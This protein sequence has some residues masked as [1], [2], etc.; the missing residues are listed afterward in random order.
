MPRTNNPSD[1][2]NTTNSSALSGVYNESDLP[3]YEFKNIVAFSTANEMSIGQLNMMFY[4]LSHGH[5]GMHLSTLTRP[6]FFLIASYLAG[7]EREYHVDTDDT[8]SYMM[9]F[10]GI[11]WSFVLDM[12]VWFLCPIIT[13]INRRW[14]IIQL[15]KWCSQTNV[16]FMEE[17]NKPGKRYARGVEWYEL[18]ALAD[19]NYGA[20]QDVYPILNLIK[21]LLEVLWFYTLTPNINEAMGHIFSTKMRSAVKIVALWARSKV[22]RGFIA[23]LNMSMYSNSVRNPFQKFASW[24]IH[25]KI[26]TSKE[27]PTKP[28]DNEPQRIPPFICAFR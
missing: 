21:V 25:K 11:F 15:E 24:D 10:K 20:M 5:V 9:F 17:S 1:N 7:N 27:Y 22:V 3:Q 2:E 19:K 12:I 28:L 6:V 4:A 8:T 16:S 18:C 13:Y 14:V 26:T 23:L